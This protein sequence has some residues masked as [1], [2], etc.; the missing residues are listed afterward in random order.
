[1]TQGENQSRHELL[2]QLKSNYTIVKCELLATLD[3]AWPLTA[4]D[5]FSS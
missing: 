5:K 2:E 4:N 3:K 1:M